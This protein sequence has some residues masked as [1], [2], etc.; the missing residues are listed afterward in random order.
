MLPEWL[1]P[2]IAPPED[3]AYSSP[4]PPA[5]T[6]FCNQGT[7]AE[8]AER[9]ELLTEVRRALREEHQRLRDEWAE[10]ERRLLEQS[11]RLAGR[12]LAHQSGQLCGLLEAEL[13]RLL[14]SS[15]SSGLSVHQPNGDAAGSNDCTPNPDVTP[16]ES[17]RKLRLP[18][19]AV[20]SGG[21]QLAAWCPDASPDEAGHALAD[22]RG[23]SFTISVVHPSFNIGGS[24]PDAAVEGQDCPAS[25]VRSGLLTPRVCASPAEH[26]PPSVTSGASKRWEDVENKSEMKSEENERCRRQWHHHMSSR[27][28]RRL[29]GMHAGQISRR[30]SAHFGMRHDSRSHS[31]QARL[32]T[33]RLE[34][35]V[36]SHAFHTFC[37]LMIVA[38]AIFIGIQT[39]MSTK[40]ALAVPPKLNPP[41]FVWCGNAFVAIFIAEVS[42]RIAAKRRQFIVGKDWRWNVADVALALLSVVEE[43]MQGFNLSYTRLVRGFHMVR[44]LRV[45]RVMRFFRELRLMVCSII[46]SLVSLS[47]ALVLL[48]LI[49]YLFAICFMHAATIYLL[50]DVTQEVRPQLSDSYGSVGTTMFSLLMAVSG[51]VDWISL[52]QPLA[53]ISAFYQ[54]LFAFYVLFVIT[55]VL[56]VLT[57]AFVQRACEFSKL[58]RDLVVQ[59][60]MNSHQAFLTTM[61]GIFEEVDADGTGRITWHK[62]REYLQNE[63]AQAYFS[64]HQLDTSDAR[65]LFLLLD[66][67]EDEEV[68]IEDFILGCKRLR[69]QARS[70]DV[71][72]LLRESKRMG[73]KNIRAMRKV[74]AQLGYILGAV[75][76]SAQYAWTADGTAGLGGRSPKPRTPGSMRSRCTPFGGC[77]LARSTTT[78]GSSPSPSPRT[79]PPRARSG[80]RTGGD[81]A[82]GQSVA[83]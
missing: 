21:R 14:S 36:D 58:D 7:P 29:G 76:S 71:Q 18:A 17:A 69:G 15:G 9:L 63:H 23:E 67:N 56:N 34:R 42:F 24:P 64:A 41:W 19:R 11:A 35:I 31:E 81:G 83:I 77:H 72:A 57:G 65:E 46:H 75:R 37:G 22:A 8:G 1:R 45:I 79:R 61:K 52:V 10:T 16:L 47:W 66:V 48:L 25:G 40:S 68:G 62:F 60:E 43:L 38:N 49:M 28:S 20:R 27:V 82:R 78:L 51:G 74:E 70:S 6:C 2:A 30:I 32:P 26:R 13:R 12:A 4:V 80:E 59:S 50:E 54:V 53:E 3:A 33:S 5:S 73:Q 44:V 55:G 39:D